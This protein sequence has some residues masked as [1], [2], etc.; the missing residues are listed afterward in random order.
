[1]KI[2]SAPKALIALLGLFSLSANAQLPNTVANP[3]TIIT[4]ITKG[5]LVI[6]SLLNNDTA[7]GSGALHLIAVGIPK[8]GKAEI[9]T[10]NGVKIVEYTPNT[11]FKG[12]DSF[13]YRINDRANGT[14]NSSISTV[15]ISNPFI[16]GR[17][18][19][20]AI[21]SGQG[22]SQD[23]S[24]YISMKV[25][26]AGQFSCL[27]RFAGKSY[28]FKSSFDIAQNGRFTGEIARGDLPFVTLELDYA[29]TGSV[30]QITGAAIVAAERIAIT[31]PRVVWSNLTPASAF[32]S[33]TVL[34]PAPNTSSTTPQGHGFMT[35]SIGRTGSVSCLG[36]T[37][38]G[39]NFSSSTFL[40]VT[41]TTAPVY[42]IVNTVA[43]IYGTLSITGIAPRAANTPVAATGSL[44]WSSVKNAARRRFPKGFNLAVAARGGIYTKPFA[45]TISNPSQFPAVLKINS[46]VG[47]NS[48]FTVSGGDLSAART[49]SA[50]IRSIP[51]AGTYEFAFD[52]ARRFAAKLVV[53][54]KDGTFSGSFYDVTKRA[55]RNFKGI[56]LQTENKA[57]GIWE[58][59]TKTG[60]IELTPD[61]ITAP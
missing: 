10:V 37:G 36:R 60:K 13:N 12:T 15:T 5:K 25:S 52:N 32:G 41:G 34:L 38:D 55:R 54:P 1:M 39:R 29:L 49:E 9:K 40:G 21:I 11:N 16:S 48:D 19:Y 3:D 20:G 8:F 6:S 57:F 30:R 47:H 18:N 33:Y 42:G 46:L 4:N 17:G 61:A 7:L 26:P 58:S 35:M 2:N 24:G 45:G 50:T 23:V 53:S 31:A 44:K 56:F 27:F 14:G 51:I 59:P 22:G 28:R 43:S